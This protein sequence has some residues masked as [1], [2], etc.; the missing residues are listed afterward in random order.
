[1][2]ADP[3]RGRQRQDGRSLAVKARDRRDAP[4]RLPD[5]GDDISTRAPT[6]RHA[7][8]RGDGGASEWPIVGARG[9][10]FAVSIEPWTMIETFRARQSA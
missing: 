2:P 8:L 9:T 4:P 10:S 1:M 7:G 3:A 5:R 6:R